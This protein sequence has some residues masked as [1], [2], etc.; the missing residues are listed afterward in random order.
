[1]RSSVHQVDEDVLE[2]ALRRLQV[3][4]PDAGGAQSLEQRGDAGALALRV[5][6]VDRARAPSGAA[7]GVGCEAPAALRSSGCCR[8][9]VSCFLPSLRISSALSSTRMISPLRD[10][11]DAVGHLLGFVD[12][13]RGQDDRDAGS[14]Q[15]AHQRPHVAP[16]LDVDAGGRLVEEQDARLVR[17]RLGDQHAALHAARERHDLA[18]LLVPQ[19]EVAQHLLDVR[20]DS[21]RLPNRPRLNDDRRPHRLERVGRELLRHEPDQ[22]ARGAVVA[23]DVVAVDRDPAVA[24]GL[25]MPQID[26]DQRGL[27]RA[28]RAEQ[29]EDLAAA[30]LEVDV[31]QRVEPRRVGLG[32]ILTEMMGCMTPSGAWL[33]CCLVL[34]HGVRPRFCLVLRC[35]V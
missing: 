6:G 24:G 12:V 34:L 13:V 33:R 27:A 25:T 5:V 16:Q 10:D 8:C 26:A 19:R 3:L 9:S 30:D 17:Q 22:R 29:R 23:H 2:R 7:R 11:A 28:V 35:G 4:E 18:V 1:M 15:P 32:E 31:L 21:A 14:L 20:R